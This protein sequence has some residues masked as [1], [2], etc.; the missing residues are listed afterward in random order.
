MA[1]ELN[2]LEAK[3]KEMLAELEGFKDLD[4]DLFDQKSTLL[5]NHCP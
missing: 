3:H 4:P 1:N 5:A 2:A